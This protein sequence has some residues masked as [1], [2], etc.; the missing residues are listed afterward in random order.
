[1]PPEGRDA[2]S[3]RAIDPSLLERLLATGEDAPVMEERL[4]IANAIR[5]SSREAGPLLDTYLLERLLDAREGLAKAGRA[6]SEIAALV[7]RLTAPPWVPARYIGA[8]DTARGRLAMVVHG[9]S[10]RA[11]AFGPDV[12]P[13]ALQVG[14]E[15]FLN[16]ELNLLVGSGSLGGAAVGETATFLRDAG[17]GRCVL[18]YRDQE[19]VV[20]AAGCLQDGALHEGDLVRWDHAAW[21]AVE[22]MGGTPS[23]KLFLED[24]PAEDFALIGGHDRQ[25][26][27]LKRA[28]TL[29]LFHPEVAR[30]Y[31][32]RPKR[33]VLLVGG[34]GTGKTMLARALAHWVGEISPSRRSR[35]MNIKPAELHSVWYSQSEANYREAF[36]AAREAAQADTSVPVVMFFDEVDA[37]GSVRGGSLHQIDDR[38]LTAFMAELD[39]LESRGNI[40][41][42]AATNRRDVL[43]PALL[44]P[45]RL[46]DLVLEVGR[47][48]ARAAREIFGKYLRCELPYAGVA[49]GADTATEVREELIEACVSRLYAPNAD[50]QLA[51]ITFRDGRRQ[52]VR[53]ADM[54]SGARI[55]NAV[56]SATERAVTR[57]IETG[58]AG[59]RAEDLLGALEDEFESAARALTP[60]NSHK[61]LTDLPADA[62]VVRVEPVV[63][64]VARPRR[65]VA[66]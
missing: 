29:H 51:T 48:D 54:V 63:R 65:Y 22:R 46:G 32:L 39:G 15:V 37:I 30:R 18:R 19:I 31:S 21:V 36:R 5:R 56:Q 2:L 1:M 6:Q 38:V 14:T 33:S 40:L 64:K 44:R 41:V 66:A 23:E 52:D 47:P 55:A 9:Q 60:F 35:F 8:L 13:E 3:R 61:H 4:A 16:H 34:P 45:G 27:Q 62:D 20:Q 12:E 58:E 28:I 7:E 17:N 24:T 10:R 53:A 59:L 42:V 57:E 50:N 43:D 49:S 25:I 11:V 26:A